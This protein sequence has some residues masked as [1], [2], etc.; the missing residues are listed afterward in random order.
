MMDKAR[1]IWSA[2]WGRG[3]NIL[4]QFTGPDAGNDKCLACGVI[5]KL[6]RRSTDH[7]FKETP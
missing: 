2:V 1:A 7:K 5:R 6:H 4:I 3:I